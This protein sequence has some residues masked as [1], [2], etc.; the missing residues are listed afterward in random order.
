MSSY[1][2]RYIPGVGVTTCA[3]NVCA[4][5]PGPE[6]PAGSQGPLVA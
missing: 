6:G 5:P 1:L 4:G 3:P 2:S